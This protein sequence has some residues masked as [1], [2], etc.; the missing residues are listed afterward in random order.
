MAEALSSGR[1][2]WRSILT[3]IILLVIIGFVNFYSKINIDP[4]ESES[5][6][7][8]FRAVNSEYG[9]SY[10]DPVS[11]RVYPGII[12]ITKFENSSIPLLQDSIDF[13][14]DNHIGARFIV[15]DF[16]GNIL[17]SGVYNNQT[18]IRKEEKRPGAGGV[19][20]KEKQLYS[21]VNYNN[22]LIPGTLEMSVVVERS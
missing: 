17:A 6:T 19:F 7:F 15:K 12:D 20:V 5:E 14:K 22:Q 8:V 21:L 16:N 18:F 11:G 2:L 13:G 10:V 3:I 9:I 1:I 4:F